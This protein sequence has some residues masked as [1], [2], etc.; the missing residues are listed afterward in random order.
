MQNGT[1]E[2]SYRLRMETAVAKRY[3]K[4]LLGLTLERNMEDVIY[5]DMV[6]ISKVCSGN[7]DFS[8]MLKSPIIIPDK[9]AAIIKQLFGGKL[10]D[11][12][13][14]FI[15]IIITKRRESYIG[16]IAEE[17]IKQYN[18]EKGIRIAYLTTAAPINEQIRNE[19]MQILRE[20]VPGKI[21]LKERIDKDMMGGFIL[22]SGD[23]QIDTSISRKI[24]ALKREF[25]LN[26]YIRD[27]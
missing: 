3:A 12:T 13:M 14:A 18:E 16:Q 5:E 8:L 27:Y 22:R 21:L 9:K 4:S 7:K 26:L 17:Y 2:I 11:V 6:L 25:K 1:D 24:R 10:N 23:K 20:A 15:N 19:V